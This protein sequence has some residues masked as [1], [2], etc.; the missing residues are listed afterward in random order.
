MT[1][2]V[3]GANGFVGGALCRALADARPLRRPE[4]EL[5][6]PVDPAL[7]AG[8]SAVVHCAW[9]L[10]SKDGRVNVDGTLRLF[11]AAMAAGVGQFVFI[12][13]MAAHD[14]ARSVYGRT[15]L[16]V[17]KELLRRGGERAA[18]VK[19]GTVIGDGGLVKSIQ[20]LAAKLPALPLFYATK[21]RRLQTVWI[22]DLTD[23]IGKIVERTLAGEFAVADET[24]VTIREFYSGVAAGKTLVRCWGDG[25]LMATAVAE[26][27]GLKLPVSS[28]NLLGLKYLRHAPTAKT[29]QALGIRPRR[30]VQSRA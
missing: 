1:V 2:A 18:V 16:E 23:A 13:S 30:F 29:N 10:R 17:E 21:N 12:S 28:D 20:T 4:Y 25:A 24:G 7:L 6:K 26:W 14:A 11:E 3:T 27:V 15:K 8:V 19:P 9:D 5:A 22:D